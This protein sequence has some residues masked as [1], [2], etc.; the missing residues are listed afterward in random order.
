MNNKTNI[1]F[2]PGDLVQFINFKHIEPYGYYFE[3]DKRRFRTVQNIFGQLGLILRNITE[4]EFK[5]LFFYRNY[6]DKFYK[7]R[8]RKNLPDWYCLL[9]ET[10]RVFVHCRYFMRLA[11]C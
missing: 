5:D 7:E 2:Q 9:Y 6:N 4:T 3:E 10:E 11:G 1:E 8:L